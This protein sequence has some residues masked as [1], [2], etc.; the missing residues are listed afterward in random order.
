[1]TKARVAARDK[2]RTG[3]EDRLIE[4]SPRALEV[5]SSSLKRAR[6]KLAGK[7]NHD[8]SLKT[9]AAGRKPSVPLGPAGSAA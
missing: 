4:L 5:L 7:L 8:S 3:S 9:P 1:M 6:L 2:D